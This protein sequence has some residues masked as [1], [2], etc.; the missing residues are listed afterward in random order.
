MNLKYLTTCGHLVCRLC[1]C[2]ILFG[3]IVFLLALRNIHLI[4]LHFENR[5]IDLIVCVVRL[6]TCIQNSGTISWLFRMFIPQ[7]LSKLLYYSQ[8]LHPQLVCA[9]EHRSLRVCIS[10]T[11]SACYICWSVGASL[12]CLGWV[13]LVD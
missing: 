7:A 5:C 1:N 13:A 9:V 8:Q 6:V 4:L 12:Y 2:N 11:F 3:V 10:L